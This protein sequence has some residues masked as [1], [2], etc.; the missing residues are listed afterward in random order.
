[1]Y[2]YQAG[3]ELEFG[4]R[5]DRAGTFLDQPAQLVRLLEERKSL[6]LVC[7]KDWSTDMCKILGRPLEPAGGSGKNLLF[8]VKA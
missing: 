7:E 6:F 1:M 2:Q 5:F 4:S 3:K 8:R